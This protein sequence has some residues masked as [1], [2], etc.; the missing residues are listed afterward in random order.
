MI[1]IAKAFL[2]CIE[3]RRSE[4]RTSYAKAHAFN[5]LQFDFIHKPIRHHRYKHQIEIAI[6]SSLEKRDI[7]PSLQH[8]EQKAREILS[9]DPHKE[10]RDFFVNTYIN[11]EVIYLGVLLVQV[12][13]PKWIMIL[14][15]AF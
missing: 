6:D 7:I 10:D 3:T 4:L 12:K 2:K 1:G 9:I 14:R 5:E 11:D 8:A 13:D 15:L